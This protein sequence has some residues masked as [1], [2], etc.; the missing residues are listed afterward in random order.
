MAVGT[1]TNATVTRDRLI[2]LAHN[3][4]GVLPQGETLD[5]DQL[6]MGLTCSMGSSERSMSQGSGCGR[7]KRPRT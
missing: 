3:V 1:T 5:G 6:R 4:I 2:E 7:S